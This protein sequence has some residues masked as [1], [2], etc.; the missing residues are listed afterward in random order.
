MKRNEHFYLTVNITKKALFDD[1]M[2]GLIWYYN[3]YPVRSSYNY[4]FG[5]TNKSLLATSFD[6]GVFEA[7]YE[8][9]LVTPYN[10]DCDKALLQI[11][12]KYPA[13]RPATFY[14]EQGMIPV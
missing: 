10:N 6:R 14:K 3:G 13:F 1:T 11:L 12:N 9:F 5:N 8:G 4:L 2:K 7:K